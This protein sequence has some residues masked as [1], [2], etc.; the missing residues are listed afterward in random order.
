MK[1]VRNTLLCSIVATS[2]M[3]LFS[4]SISKKE[5]ENFEEPKLLGNFVKKTFQTSKKASAFSGWGL[6]YLT[7]VV[8]AVVYKLL[9]GSANKRPSAANG[10]LYGTLAGGAGVVSWDILFKN[11]RNPPQT[12]R[13][14]FYTQL[15][16]AH[17]IF[18]LTLSAFREK[19][20]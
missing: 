2:T 13:K 12:D 16:I 19:N 6:H 11:H 18:G 1:S 3:T 7:G 10:L 20:R 14:G 4:Y 5:G 9:L 17:I 8:F 15:V